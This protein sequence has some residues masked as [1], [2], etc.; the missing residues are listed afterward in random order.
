MKLIMTDHGRSIYETGHYRV[1]PFHL[2]RA[3]LGG[4]AMR[5]YIYPK[6]SERMIDCVDGV[7]DPVGQRSWWKFWELDPMDYE[8]RSIEQARTLAVAACD[9]IERELGG[10]AA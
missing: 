4:Y 2:G 8:V 3:V 5:F 10:V 1:V 9:R 6:G 7:S